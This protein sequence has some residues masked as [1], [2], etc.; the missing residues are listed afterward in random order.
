VVSVTILEKTEILGL[1]LEEAFVFI[2]GGTAS[3]QWYLQIRD[4][5]TGKRHR[6]SLGGNC[7]GVD[8]KRE[9]ILEGGKKYFGFMGKIEK[10]EQLRSLSVGEMCKRFLDREKSRVSNI[11]HR[12]ITL[13]RYRFLKNHTEKMCEF[14][15]SGTYVDKITRERFFVYPEWRREWARKQQKREVTTSTIKQEMSTFKKILKEIAWVDKYIQSIPAFP[16]VI[17]R[18]KESTIRRDGFREREWNLFTN[19]ISAIKWAVT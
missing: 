17:I 15:G 7:R 11:P 3:Q 12:G 5:N 1:P 4:S 2:N 19:R 6:F 9:A 18:G 14:L 8:K 13:T 16:K 10:G